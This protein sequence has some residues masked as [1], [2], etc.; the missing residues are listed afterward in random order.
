[1]VSQ[2]TLLDMDFLGSMLD[3]GFLDI[4][5][6]TGL[7]GNIRDKAS[8]D[9][10]PD[11]GHPDNIVDTGTPGILRDIPLLGNKWDIRMTDILGDSTSRES[12]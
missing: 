12:K 7:P 4:P 9:M 5:V 6:D 10:S 2:D 1:M 11:S 8:W 3:M